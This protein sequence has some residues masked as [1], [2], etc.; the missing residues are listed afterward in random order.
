[1]PVFAYQQEESVNLKGV[2]MSLH[3]HPHFLH[4]LH[5]EENISII[6]GRNSDNQFLPLMPANKFQSKLR[7]YLTKE[8]K[9]RCKEIS[10]D[11]VYYASQNN[12]AL[13]E[14]PSAAYSLINTA[15]HFET[16]NKNLN[17][18]IGV[19]NVLNQSYIPH[20]SRLKSYEI[21]SVGRSYYFKLCLTL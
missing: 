13:N 10:L 11:H 12:V 18:S 2:E 7:Y 3:Y 19:K 14:T 4:Q 15:L 17:L 8:N 16:K 20:L 5:F 6:E 9:Y 21:P 1:M